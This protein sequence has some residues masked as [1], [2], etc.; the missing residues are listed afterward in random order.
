M[1]A[2]AIDGIKFGPMPCAN[3]APPVPSREEPV[4]KHVEWPTGVGAVI[5][6]SPQDAIRVTHHEEVQQAHFASVL[7]WNFY[8]PLL[9]SERRQRLD[10]ICR[11]QNAYARIVSVGV[12]SSNG[13]DV[14]A[15][16]MA[17]Q[18]A[19]GGSAAEEG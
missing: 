14:D 19:D 15:T 6:E 4:G 9:R 12:L 17:W 16:T 3:E 8:M 10:L 11:Q 1:D 5:L 2:R 18:Q 13:A 7:N